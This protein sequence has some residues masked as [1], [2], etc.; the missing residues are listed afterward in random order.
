MPLPCNAG[1]QV[2]QARLNVWFVRIVNAKQMHWFRA[3][4]A[5]P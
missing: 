1:S 5:V 2:D 3:S 4:G